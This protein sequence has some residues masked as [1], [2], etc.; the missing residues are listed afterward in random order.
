MT[1]FLAETEKDKA[2]ENFFTW[3]VLGSLDNLNEQSKSDPVIIAPLPRLLGIGDNVDG[4]GDVLVVAAQA[5]GA[6]GILYPET[7]E[8][9][10]QKGI[11][12][13]Y[14]LPSS[15]YEVL[16][17]PEKMGISGND[18]IDL[19]R[20]VNESKVE[21]EDRLSYDVLHYVNGLWHKVRR[22]TR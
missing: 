21:P 6:I 20:E 19:V 8:K 3:P 9:L 11:T 4:T 1:K 5:G 7:L 13:F 22:E 17:M 12:N 2:T 18:L 14:V 16:V 10:K 15:V